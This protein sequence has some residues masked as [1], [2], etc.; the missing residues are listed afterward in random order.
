MC[1]YGK[2]FHVNIG[3]NL[4]RKFLTTYFFFRKQKFVSPFSKCHNLKTRHC[5]KQVFIFLLIS[6]L[7]SITQCIAG[8]MD[9]PMKILS[10]TGLLT[11]NPINSYNYFLKFLG[12]IL[13]F[14][15][16]FFLRPRFDYFWQQMEFLFGTKLFFFQALSLLFWRQIKFFPQ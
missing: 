4:A 14:L 7:C 5:P 2:T 11:T 12:I 10:Q 6:V 1:N 9:A 8:A 13:N 16:L 15:A 3:H